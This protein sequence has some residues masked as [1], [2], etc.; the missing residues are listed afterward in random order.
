MVARALREAHGRL[1]TS[2]DTLQHPQS[3]VQS[4][5]GPVAQADALLAARGAMKM[6]EETIKNLNGDNKT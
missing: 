6:G 2:K 1:K 4:V 5:V 3:P